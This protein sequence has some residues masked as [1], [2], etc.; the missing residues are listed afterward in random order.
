MEYEA[1]RRMPADSRT[2]FDV[3]A[4]LNRIGNWLPGELH[5]EPAEPGVIK[6]DGD[7]LPSDE[8]HEGLWRVSDDQLRLEWGSRD[9]PD[10]SG[11]LQVADQQDGG[12]EVTLHLSFLADQPEA[13]GD[14]RRHTET[15]RLLE[16]SL[17]RLA[18]EIR[19]GHDF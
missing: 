1:N 14:A 15:Q 8:T 6:A 19:R 4:D 9:V 13:S 3:A 10:Y 2:T 12:S 17:D 7:L 16:Q 18:G 11:W 5:V